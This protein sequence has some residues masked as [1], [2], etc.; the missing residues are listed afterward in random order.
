MLRCCVIDTFKFSHGNNAGDGFP[1][2]IASA[3]FGA[4]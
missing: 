4:F 1:V 3:I 2:P